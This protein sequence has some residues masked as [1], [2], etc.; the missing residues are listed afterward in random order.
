MANAQSVPGREPP[1]ANPEIRGTEGAR[2]EVSAKGGVD[3]T[4]DCCSPQG[5]YV[6][7]ALGGDPAG[8]AKGTLP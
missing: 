5:S 7:A 4:R 1:W 2:C 8:T 3:G 6:S